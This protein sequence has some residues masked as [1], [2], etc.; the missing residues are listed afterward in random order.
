MEDEDRGKEEEGDDGD[1][2]RLAGEEGGQLFVL[3]GDRMVP[4]SGHGVNFDG[5][6]VRFIGLL[7]FVVGLEWAGV[8]TSY[9]SVAQAG[10][11][12]E[13]FHHET[14]HLSHAARIDDQ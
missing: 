2:E 12:A 1:V 6:M 3:A 4:S 8:D 7:G 9:K 11:K 10:E 14:E 5:F 13:L